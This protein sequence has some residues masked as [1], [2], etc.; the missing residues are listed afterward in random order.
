MAEQRQAGPDPVDFGGGPIRGDLPTGW[1]HGTRPGVRSTDP[2]LQVHRV[3]EHTFVLRQTKALTYEA[4]FL[5]LLLGND[6]ALLLD[7]GDVADAEQMPLRQTVDA[8]VASWLSR[9][10]RATYPLVVAHSHGHRDHVRGDGQFA[11]RPHTT[12]VPPDVDA[13]RDFF[14]LAEQ[15]ASRFDL[16]GRVLDVLHCPGHHAASAVLFDPWTGFLLT[17]DTVYPG[18]LYVQDAPAFRTSVH[19]LADFAGQ[20]PVT[21]VM[22]CHI[23]MT[24]TPGRDYPVGSRYQPDEPPL[25]MTVAQLQAVAAAADQVVDK[26]GVHVYDDFAIFNGRCLTG[27]A[28]QILR[29][30]GRSLSLRLRRTAR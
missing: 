19:R 17:G 18:R 24:R 12:V 5:Y 8:L 20:R 10:P 28:R 25:E 11:G 15:C 30:W 9:H 3:D 1:I 6:R 22:G 29:L 27:V 4:P 16:G 13:V 26:P 23:E 21:A 14:G 7:T 2:P